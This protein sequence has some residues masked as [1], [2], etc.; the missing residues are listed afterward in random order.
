MRKRSSQS[1]SD[2]DKPEPCEAIFIVYRSPAFACQHDI[3]RGE[4]I[5]AF[6]VIRLRLCLCRADG[7]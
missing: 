4:C 7:G 3:K 5:G 1:R 6:R 2:R